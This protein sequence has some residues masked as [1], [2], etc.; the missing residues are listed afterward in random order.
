MLH[1]STNSPEILQQ[2][3]GNSTEGGSKYPFHRHSISVV[4]VQLS[5][6]ESKG[7]SHIYPPAAGTINNLVFV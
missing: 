6:G 5:H 7:E 2:R 1:E 4:P 3:E